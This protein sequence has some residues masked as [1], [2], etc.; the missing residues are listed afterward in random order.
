MVSAVSKSS[1][2]LDPDDNLPGLT[3]PASIARTEGFAAAVDRRA[4]WGE[5]LATRRPIGSGGIGADLARRFTGMGTSTIGPW[6]ARLVERYNS[7]AR[8]ADRSAELP[9]ASSPAPRR[10]ARAASASAW[11]PQQAR[12]LAETHSGDVP[13]D[14]ARS[15]ASDLSAHGWPVQPEAGTPSS[16][17]QANAAPLQP[18]ARQ[19]SAAPAP[20]LPTTG[21][22]ASMPA[23]DERSPSIGSA[24]PPSEQS[25][26][27]SP[28]AESAQ[29]QADA[30]A[31]TAVSRAVEPVQPP[32]SAEAS[33]TMPRSVSRPKMQAPAGSAPQAGTISEMNSTYA[34]VSRDE[35]YAKPTK[36][37]N[38]P[39]AVG[40]AQAEPS[41]ISEDGASRAV[42]PALAVSGASLSNTPLA[43]PLVTQRSTALMRQAAHNPLARMGFSTAQPPLEPTA[44]LGMSAPSVL[45]RSAALTPT[46]PPA[47]AQPAQ[48]L[49]DLPAA[50]TPSLAAHTSAQPAPELQLPS[51]E[52]P[53]PTPISAGSDAPPQPFAGRPLPGMLA[54]SIA[55]R[56]AAPTSAMATQLPALRTWAPVPSAAPRR[57]DTGGIGSL[58]NSGTRVSAA[59]PIARAATLAPMSRPAI[60]PPA[61]TASA[62]QPYAP[63]EASAPLTSDAL[64]KPAAPAQPRRDQPAEQIEWGALPLIRRA[65]EH[66]NALSAGASAGSASLPSQ[67]VERQ[68]AFAPTALAASANA[69][70]HAAQR[71]LGQAG[72]PAVDRIFAASA[73]Q[74]GAYPAIFEQ[75]GMAPA[76]QLGSRDHE[77]WSTPE[78]PLHDRPSERAEPS[79]YMAQRIAA[80]LPLATRGAARSAEP[81]GSPAIYLREHGEA[82]EFE[83]SSPA[84]QRAPALDPTVASATPA[85]NG[86]A[87]AAGAAPTAGSPPIDELARKVYD[88]L[89]RELRVEQERAGWRTW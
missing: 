7:G 54:T 21:A 59:P 28:P 3:P 57:S 74:I 12:D 78:L 87:P 34:Q 35:S 18:S 6:A 22:D 26:A 14:L 81:S 84:L 32:S 43:L 44:R 65:L 49:A 36:L 11:A 73:P 86:S 29:P 24:R 39:L 51:S 4:T 48:P 76:G 41:A 10:V 88:Y 63:T 13:P 69:A 38:S 37:A 20:I 53:V 85:S 68:A 33:P 19:A 55:Q 77:A 46:A 75:H 67:I 5:Q 15:F 83:G 62:A 31:P 25:A 61:A 30:D 58:P 82:P 64:H 70:S 40:P 17:R 47:S 9:L 42:S 27:S 71:A 72:A 23:L 8:A 50:Q 16:A 66:T 52:A 80:E 2:M 89:R 45:A 79:A 1:A 56:L 60:V